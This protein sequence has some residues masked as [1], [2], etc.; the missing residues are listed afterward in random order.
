[1]TPKA[2]RAPNPLS[3]PKTIFVVKLP[4][5]PSSYKQAFDS[6]DEL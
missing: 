4:H 3:L 2:R 6:D 1:M 5:G